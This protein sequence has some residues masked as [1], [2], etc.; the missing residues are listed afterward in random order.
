MPSTAGSSSSFT[1]ET[2]LLSSFFF[3]YLLF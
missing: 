2:F 3:I 1:G